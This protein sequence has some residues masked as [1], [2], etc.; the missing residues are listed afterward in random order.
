[1]GGLH[2]VLRN[3]Y[4]RATNTRLN[5]RSSDHGSFVGSGVSGIQNPAFRQ[6]EMSRCGLATVS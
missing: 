1:M 2:G 3:P 6:A 4:R 5:M